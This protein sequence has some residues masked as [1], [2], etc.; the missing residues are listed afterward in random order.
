MILYVI[1]KALDRYHGLYKLKLI[2]YVYYR[3]VKMLLIFKT[4]IK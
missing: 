1:I 2:P 3:D 4:I